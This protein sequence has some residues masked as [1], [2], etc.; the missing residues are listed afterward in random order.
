MN[1]QVAVAVDISGV[2]PPQ[3]TIKPTKFSFRTDKDT[4]TKRPTVDLDI[5]VPTWDGLLNALSDSTGKVPELVLSAIQE[6]VIAAVREQV[7]DSDKPVSVQSDLDTAKLT[8]SYLANLPP[9]ARAER[10][11]TAEMWEEFAESMREVYRVRAPNR[12]AETTETA[13]RMF[14]SSLKGHRGNVLILAAAKKLLN[15]W[16]SALDN[17]SDT[18]GKIYNHLTNKIEA[19]SNATQEDLLSALAI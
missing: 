9:S 19:F 7:N 13:I 8:L 2:A 17:P 12:P 4:G 18:L 15:F 16:F 10:S 6:L 3:F 14:Q 1:D 11:I 5:P